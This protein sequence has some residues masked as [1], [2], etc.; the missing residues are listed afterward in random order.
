MQPGNLVKLNETAM[1]SIGLEPKEKYGLIVGT[2]ERV[3]AG[4]YN[5]KGTDDLVKLMV[6]M[7]SE[8]IGE[9]FE[10]DLILIGA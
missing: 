7:S 2:N 8:F 5:S 6:V 1:L 10:D 4:H 9:F 3:F